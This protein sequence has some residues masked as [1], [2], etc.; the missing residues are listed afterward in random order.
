[1]E[2]VQ[3]GVESVKDALMYFS[4]KIA[5]DA[6]YN[7]IR[8]RKSVGEYTETECSNVFNE[9]CLERNAYCAYDDSG[10]IIGLCILVSTKSILNNAQAYKELFTD[11]SGFRHMFEGETEMLFMQSLYGDSDDIVHALIEH[12]QSL[13]SDK[14]IITDL[15]D[16]DK[17]V[18]ILK[19]AG[20]YS[21]Y[22]GIT[23]YY[24]WRN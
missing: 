12:V 10:N 18:S 24:V 1:M 9:S 21:D 2:I 15:K 14:I 17:G 13:N 19:S 7:C 16:T 23:N 6:Y 8:G 5:D 4:T 11:S 20:F 22:Y 3:I